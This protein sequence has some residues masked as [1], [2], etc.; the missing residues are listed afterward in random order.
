MPRWLNELI[1]TLVTTTGDPPPTVKWFKHGSVLD[2]SFDVGSDGIVRNELLIER[3]SRLDLLTVLTCQ[4]SNT[5]RVASLQVS[6]SLDL[7][8]K[9][10]SISSCPSTLVFVFCQLF[11]FFFFLTW[12]VFSV[13][14]IEEPSWV[15]CACRISIPF[16][17]RWRNE[18]E[19]CV[20]RKKRV[21]S[22]FFLLAGCV[23]LASQENQW[24]KEE[25]NQSEKEWLWE[26][27]RDTHNLDI[28]RILL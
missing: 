16:W 4:S 8:R 25:I 7:I 20:F 17:C 28:L 22:F 26:R 13:V 10:L 12:V 6:I 27:Q 1:N 9:S 14:S 2:D 24:R 5:E 21:E 3:L 23:T 18:S 15:C 11:F 19:S